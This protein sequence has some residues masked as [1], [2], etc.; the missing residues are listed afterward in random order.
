MGEKKRLGII[1][2]L[3]PAA[4]ALFYGML[5]EKTD[6]SSDG[7]HIDAVLTSFSSTPDRTAFL[8][9][10]SSESPIA[11]MKEARDL[12]VSAGVGVIAVPCNT[13]TVFF[14]E[15]QAGTDVPILNIIDETVKAA[16]RAGARKVGI[17][18]T[19]GTLRARAYQDALAR[20]GLPCAVPDG[21]RTAMLMDLIYGNIKSGKTAD[22]QAFYSVSEYLYGEGCDRI[23]LGCTELSLL[24]FPKDGYTDST[25]ALVESSIIACGYKLKK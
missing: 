20:E 21:R 22:M 25:T 17:M 15:L 19:E 10:R 16:K 24:P 11:K 3:G 9:G 14:E 6:A 1:G 18:A 4:S 2:G 7:G 23:V 8:L 12:L 13:A 5:T